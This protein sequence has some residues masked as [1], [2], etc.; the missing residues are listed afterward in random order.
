M[1]GVLPSHF[2]NIVH[3]APGLAATI[4]HNSMETLLGKLSEEEKK[5]MI[6]QLPEGQ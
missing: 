5:S 3:I 2:P 6:E 1:V 4:T